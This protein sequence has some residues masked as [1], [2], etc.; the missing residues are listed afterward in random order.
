MRENTSQAHPLSA[1]EHNRPIIEL[2]AEAEALFGWDALRSMNGRGCGGR[3]GEVA[4]AQ[5]EGGLA[6][7]NSGT[8]INDYAARGGPI[9]LGVHYLHIGAEAMLVGFK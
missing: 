1:N 2:S 7:E 4:D 9:A 3:S 6:C 5:R 8:R